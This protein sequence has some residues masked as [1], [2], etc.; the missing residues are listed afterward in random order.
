MSGKGTVSRHAGQ[1]NT[2][3]RIAA[4]RWQV[5]LREDYYA[6]KRCDFSNTVQ[7]AGHVAILAVG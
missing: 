6:T 4:I 7:G 3:E 5:G 1:T 2:N